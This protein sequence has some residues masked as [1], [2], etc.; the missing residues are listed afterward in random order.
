MPLFRRA[1]ARGC[2]WVPMGESPAIG[3]DAADAGL[4]P[5]RGSSPPAPADQSGR[6]SPTP[7]ETADRR[8]A[9]TC[10]LSAFFRREARDR[11]QVSPR[12]PRS[13]REL[14]AAMP[15]VRWGRRLP[16]S[17]ERAQP[18]RPYR[19][20]LRQTLMTVEGQTQFTERS[21]Q[22]VT[23]RPIR[24]EDVADTLADHFDLHDVPIPRSPASATEHRLD[25][26][27]DD[28]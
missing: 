11:D 2:T 22:A 6:R 28:Q 8:P 15:P 23:V 7:S 19:P 4:A 10:Q 21:P 16:R 27:Q 12:G 25:H 3:I 14:P 20:G 18:P 5:P 26:P 17:S 24:A 9:C 1:S 13:D